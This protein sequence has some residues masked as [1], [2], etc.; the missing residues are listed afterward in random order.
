MSARFLGRVTPERGRRRVEGVTVPATAWLADGT[1]LALHVTEPVNGAGGVQYFFR[2]FV[3]VPPGVL[4]SGFATVAQYETM[5]QLIDDAPAGGG[6][7]QQNGNGVAGALKVHWGNVEADLAAGN[8]AQ[9]VNAID[10]FVNLL[11]AQ[12]G[13]RVTVALSAELR[14]LAAEGLRRDVVRGRRAR[15]AQRH[16]ARGEVRVLRRA[17]VGPRRHAEA[18]LLATW[19]GGPGNRATHQRSMR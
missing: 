13:K 5:T 10:A 6:I 15:P 11:S 17:R 16:T 9:A 4:A 1:P 14:L 7:Q 12:S 3:P 2:G 8:D 19:M 18:R